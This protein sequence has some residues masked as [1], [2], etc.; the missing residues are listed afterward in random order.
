MK[1]LFPIT[2]K[3][4][5]GC[6][7]PLN[8]CEI[9]HA[10]WY[11]HIWHGKAWVDR[12]MFIMPYLRKRFLSPTTF[13]RPMWCSNHW[14]TQIPSSGYIIQEISKLPHFQHISYNKAAHLNMAKNYCFV[15]PK[16]VFSVPSLIMFATVAPSMMYFT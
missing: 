2:W 16:K 5:V 10:R 14:A 15:W 7:W 9:I 13:W 12:W 4:I 6:E 3:L 8:C 11:Q 1:E